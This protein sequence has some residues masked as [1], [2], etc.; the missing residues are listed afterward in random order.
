MVRRH[1]IRAGSYWLALV[2]AV[3]VAAPPLSLDDVAALRAERRP[4]GDVLRELRSRGRAFDVDAAARER[5]GDLGFN[6]RQVDTIAKAR[7]AEAGAGPAA[8]AVAK[9]ERS[10]EDE[11]SLDRLERAVRRAVA[12]SQGVTVVDTAHARLLLGSGVPRE[13][14]DDARRLEGL[15]AQRFPGPVA[16]GVDRRGVNI[17]LFAV[18][19]EHAAWIA[20]LE[21]ALGENGFRFAEG[22]MTFAEQARRSPAVYLDGITTMRL[23]GGADEARHAVAHAVGFHAIAQLTRG[24]C[25]D[26]LQS[27]FANV[28]ETMLC[29]AP[30]TTVRGG[31]GD[32]DIGAAAG[33]L[34]AVQQRVAAGTAGSARD[35]LDYRFDAMQ[36]P[37]YAECWSFTTALCLKP[38]KFTRLVLDLR[39]GGEPLATAAQV[40]GVDAAALTEAWKTLVGSS[41]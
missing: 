26:A 1:L 37:E 39:A 11:A 6:T 12:L 38:E 29:G 4:T 13:L 35:L 31:S 17:A 14:A 8:A 33:W 40:Y 30:A 10:P 7:K 3:A 23:T 41:R 22:G 34:Q 28:A 27:G 25:G 36:L 18:E 20:A 24:H 15:L 5:L 21:K 2:A 32:R 9:L 16:D 19:S